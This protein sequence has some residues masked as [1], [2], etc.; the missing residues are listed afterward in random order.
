MDG[1]K[2]NRRTIRRTDR[3]TDKQTD[4]SKF[5][6]L[7]K[8]WMDRWTDKQ[9]DGSKFNGRTNRQADH[10]HVTLT[11]TGKT[12]LSFKRPVCIFAFGEYN[13]KQANVCGIQ[14]FWTGIAHG[15]F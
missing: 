13:S 15:K 7:I 9:T 4:G 12:F 10:G 8:R 14:H 6:G 3:W 1:S 2:F 5:N 11:N